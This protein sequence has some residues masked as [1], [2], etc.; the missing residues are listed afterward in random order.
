MKNYY[1][2]LGIKETA[3][4][5]IIN[6]AYKY[7]ISRYKNLPFHTQ[8]MIADIKELKEAIYILTDNNKRDKYN[9]KLYKYMDYNNLSK[10]VDNTKICDR[11]F[12]ITFM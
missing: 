3:T 10:E 9:K 8:Q 4:N 5:D 12:S 2:I 1:T 7:K 6:D 11:L